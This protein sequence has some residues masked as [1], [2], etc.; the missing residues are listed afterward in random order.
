[1]P[2]GTKSRCG[3]LSEIRLQ[4]V[5]RQWKKKAELKVLEREQREREREAEIKR[6]RQTETKT[7]TKDVEEIDLVGLAHLLPSCSLHPLSICL[8]PS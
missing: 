5:I 3:L 6:Q 2:L 1:M 7:E 8:Q 4:P